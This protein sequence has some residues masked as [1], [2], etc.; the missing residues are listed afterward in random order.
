MDL[1]VR[2]STRVR[3]NSNGFKV[4]TCKAKN[5]LGCSTEPRTLSQVMIKKI[6][7][8]MCQLREDQLDEQALLGKKK[9]EPVGKKPKKNKDDNDDKKNSKDDEH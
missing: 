2:R 5:C 3:A 4:N 7:I 9:M 8:S 1:V 6:G